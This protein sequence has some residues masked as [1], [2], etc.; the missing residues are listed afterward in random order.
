MF[1]FDHQVQSIYPSH[2]GT[3]TRG[4]PA[5]AANC[6]PMAV[7][8]ERSP[9]S[10]DSDN[11][12]Y[13]TWVAWQPPCWAPRCK[14]CPILMATDEFSSHTTGK[15]FKEKFSVSWRFSN[16][17]YL[18][19]CRSCGFQFVGEMGQLLRM[20]VI[21]HW[22]DITHRRTEESP[23]VEH[24]NSGAHI[25]SDMTVMVVEFARSCGACLQKIWESRWV[26]P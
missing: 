12:M 16:V 22:Y 9:C 5:S 20:R 18:I 8:L 6:L 17:I 3:I 14:T 2:L 21:R 11:Y 24:F 15:V 7:R 26:R 1:S 23:M 25:E 19:T 13:V 10:R 4:T